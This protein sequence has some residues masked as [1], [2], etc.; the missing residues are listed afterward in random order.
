VDRDQCQPEKGVK[1]SE[2]KGHQRGEAE[3]R[4][5]K[6]EWHQQQL[7]RRFEQL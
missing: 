6:R 3:Q 1:A 4:Y 5:V 7:E 2:I